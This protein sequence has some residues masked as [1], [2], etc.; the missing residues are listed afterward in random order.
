MQKT[1]LTATARKE[2]GKGISRRIRARGRIPAVLYGRA[3]S[4]FALELDPKALVRAISTEA[5]E[6]TLID[7]SIEG[8]SDSSL[9]LVMVRE[10]QQDPVSREFLHADLYEISLDQKIQVKVPV[11]L[12]GKAKGV[13][14]GGI[15][16]HVLREVSV[17]CLP[18]RIPGHFELDVTGLSIGDS[19]HASDLRIP[20]GV[21]LLETPGTALASLA[22]PA[23]EEEKPAVAVGEE[24][25][26]IEGAVP[27][28]E[29]EAPAAGVE[30]PP[31]AR[32]SRAR[33]EEKGKD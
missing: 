19:L 27:T 28:A 29:G 21:T 10:I 20:E 1:K 25:V 2:T 32:P 13:V 24:G 17:E 7:L 22:A 6:N 3:T 18:T 23:A 30:A 14:D 9:K 12:I 31:E 5:G 16:E 8:D 33:G 15:L 4:A 26:P 11:H